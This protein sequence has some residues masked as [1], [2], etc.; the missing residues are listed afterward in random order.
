MVGLENEV[1][2]NLLLHPPFN[3]GLLVCSSAKIE[4]GSN[5]HHLRIVVFRIEDHSSQIFI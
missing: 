2:E 1:D 5:T 4:Y 3:I